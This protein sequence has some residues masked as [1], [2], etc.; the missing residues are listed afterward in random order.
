M[1]HAPHPQPGKLKCQRS[2][3]SFAKLDQLPRPGG[4]RREQMTDLPD[5]HVWSLPHRLLGPDRR[6]T[7][8]FQEITLVALLQGIEQISR[9]VPN[10]SSAVTQSKPTVLRP[11][12]VAAICGL[13]WKMISAGTR[14]FF[15]RA[16]SSAHSR[17]R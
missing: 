6:V 17:G 14:V 8:D 1:P 15:R 11:K 12:S 16:A 5:E 9:H 3:R 10:S 7:G 2:P 13:V 4:N